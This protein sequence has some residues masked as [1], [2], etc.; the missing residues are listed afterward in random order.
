M[1]CL[2]LVPTPPAMLVY[3]GVSDIQNLK[4]VHLCNAIADVRSECFTRILK[5]GKYIDLPQGGLSSD[6]ILNTRMASREVKTTA[7]TNQR[8]L[9]DSD[10]QKQQ[11]SLKSNVHTCG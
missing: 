4:E 5:L 10:W 7:G 6:I 2:K 8:Q 9:D 11:Y 3:S 1:Q